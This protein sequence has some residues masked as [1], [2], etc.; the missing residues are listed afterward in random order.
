MSTQRVGQNFLYRPRSLACAPL[1]ICFAKC[2]Q[3]TIISSSGSVS[4]S[5][6][7]TT[8]TAATVAAAAPVPVAVAATA[9]P[10]VEI[11]ATQVIG[12]VITIMASAFS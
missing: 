3:E 7:S 8:T 11:A 12:E 10:L 5:S 1:P 9:A 4:S 2:S 6:S